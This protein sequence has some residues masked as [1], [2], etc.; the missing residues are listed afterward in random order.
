MEVEKSKVEKY[1][2]LHVQYSCRYWVHHL[3]RGNID[4]Y[5]ID[6]VHIFLQKHFLHWLEALSLMGK[7]SEG[8]LMLTALQSILTV[9]DPAISHCILRC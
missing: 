8:V 9:S 5:D 2:P 7:M 4:L 3:Q 6:Q 1:L